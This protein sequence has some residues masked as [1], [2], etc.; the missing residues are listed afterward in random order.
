MRTRFTHKVALVTGGGSGIGRAVA[1]AFGREG[2]AVVVAGRRAEPLEQTVA[3]IE[4]EGGVADAVVADVSVAEDLE[5][6]M[7]TVVSRYGR[8][9]I[10]SNNAGVLGAPAPVADVEEATWSEVLG[11]NLTGLWLSMKHE[12]R[13]MRAAGGG[14]IVNTASNVGA[15][16]RVPGLGTYT[17]TKAAVSALT[18]TAALE[19]IRSGV[20]INAISPGPADTDMSRLPGESDE[21]RDARMN[22][23]LPIGRVASLDEVAAAVLWLASPE[24]SFVVGHD[25]VIDGGAT[26]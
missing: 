7:D 12:I 9:D 13:W 26:A 22:D 18:R 21:Q 4:A 5:R 16:M 19:N 2:A 15:H 8:L 24:S 20:R 14:A 25:L 10:A 6:L 1:V 11:I 3:L 23:A 17:A